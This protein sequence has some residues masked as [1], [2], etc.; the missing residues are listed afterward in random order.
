MVRGDVVNRIQFATAGL[1]AAWA[2][3][4]LEEL[5]TMSDNSRALAARLPDR[6][7]VP[8]SVRDRGLIMSSH[9]SRGAA[10]EWT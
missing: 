5:A 2:A 7:P 6:L 3:H 4:D 10:I 8:A 9:L 1:F